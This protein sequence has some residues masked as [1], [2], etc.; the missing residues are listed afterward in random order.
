MSLKVGPKGSLKSYTYSAES[1]LL[2]CV[3]LD[4]KKGLLYY[5][6]LSRTPSRD[7]G[8]TQVLALEH[9]YAPQFQH[10]AV[11]AWKGH[12]PHQGGYFLSYA[13]KKKKVTHLLSTMFLLIQLFHSI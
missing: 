9:A 6:E 10:P 11:L 12:H 7:Y 13:L 4:T 5:G 3:S 1:V 8:V 2:S